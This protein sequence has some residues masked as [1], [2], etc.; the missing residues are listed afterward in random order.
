MCHPLIELGIS[1]TS[2]L[3]ELMQGFIIFMMNMTSKVQVNEQLSNWSTF[4]TISIKKQ[5][6]QLNSAHNVS[7]T[8][9]LATLSVIALNKGAPIKNG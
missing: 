7:N 3:T 1:T 4:L 6:T 2:T 8:S 9:E 5:Y